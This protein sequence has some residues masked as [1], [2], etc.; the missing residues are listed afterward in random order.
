MKSCKCVNVGRLTGPCGV[1][2]FTA[3]RSGW[4]PKKEADSNQH[5][6]T[7]GPAL[8]DAAVLRDGKLM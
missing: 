7:V 4:A 1:K 5:I 2:L 3:A 6:L 8:C